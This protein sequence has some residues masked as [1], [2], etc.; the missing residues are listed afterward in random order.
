MST[1]SQQVEENRRA[2]YERFEA[3]RFEVDE[4]TDLSERIPLPMRNSF[5]YEMGLDGHLYYLGQSIGEVVS[6]SLSA[7]QQAELRAPGR[8]TKH[9]VHAQIERQ[10]YDDQRKL[11][12]GSAGDD[13]LL[14]VISPQD[15]EIGKHLTMIRVYERT[16]DG[17]EA[18]SISFDTSDNVCLDNVSRF[19]GQSISTTA[20]VEEVLSM[21]LW[22]KRQDIPSEDLR[23][24][25]AR[26]HDVILEE[27][28]GGVWS[29]GR[30]GTSTIDAQTF[31]RNQEDILAEHRSVIKGLIAAGGDDLVERLE[32]ARYD[33]AAQLTARLRG[34][35]EASSREAAGELARENGE[36]YSNNCPPVG[37]ELGL[38]NFTEGSCRV[39]LKQGLV[40]G[41]SVCYSC[42]LADTH[43]T[44]GRALEIIHKNALARQA[45]TRLATGQRPRTHEIKQPPRTRHHDASLVSRQRVVI[46]GMVRDIF[47]RKTGQHLRTENL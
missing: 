20:S 19:F 25:I 21:R 33:T 28:R 30:V 38:T 9:L 44:T 11:A 46:G 27:T 6:T 10:E 17:L 45:L 42:E 43:D 47:D 22:G 40:G 4:I 34:Q 26:L 16:E 29:G 8:F 5:R 35:A 15:H 1:V 2:Q 14:I 41:C 39:C 23:G 24:F 36:T 3:E 12:C 37:L 13:D 31:I 32:N 7:A 18:T